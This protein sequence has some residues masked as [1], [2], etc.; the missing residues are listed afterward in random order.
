MKL[1]DRFNM[2]EF[3]V[4]DE[5]RP[6]IPCPYCYEEFDIGSLCTHL[7]DEHSCESR[8][9]VCFSFSLPPLIFIVNFFFGKCILWLC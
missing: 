3:E 1:L 5:I 2:D 8:A 6:D 4:E 9:T 7:D